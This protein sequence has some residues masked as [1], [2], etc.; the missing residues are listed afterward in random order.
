MSNLREY[1]VTAIS[2]EVLD[3]LCNDI[4]SPGGSLYIPNR[5]VQVANQ[6]SISRNTHYFLSDE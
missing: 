3:D 6:R 5:Q 4:E 1:V 2:Y